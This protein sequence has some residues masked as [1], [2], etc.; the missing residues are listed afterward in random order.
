MFCLNFLPSL[1]EWWVSV[2][3]FIKILSNFFTSIKSGSPE[4]A[5]NAQVSNSVA[6]S[7]SLTRRRMPS[8]NDGSKY[9][10][11]V[12]TGCRQL[13]EYTGCSNKKIRI[14]I[15]WYIFFLSTY[16]E[17]LCL[18]RI[19]ISEKAQQVQKKSIKLE[20]NTMY[21]NLIS[22]IFQCKSIGGWQWFFILFHL[23]K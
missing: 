1:F 2:K 6:G 13:K 5:R 22:Q 15:L 9:W 20:W 23:D 19:F 3:K 17:N 8:N 21:W 18:K 11:R 12:V 14:A 4:R 16:T 7:R 10:S